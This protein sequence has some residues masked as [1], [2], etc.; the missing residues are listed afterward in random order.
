MPAEQPST[1]STP[2]GTHCSHP[3]QRTLSLW[4]ELY[5]CVSNFITDQKTLTMRLVLFGVRGDLKSTR[6]RFVGTVFRTT[7]LQQGKTEGAQ[8]ERPV[9]FSAHTYTAQKHSAAICYNCI[10]IIL[11]FAV[12][13]KCLGFFF[14]KHCKKKRIFLFRNSATYYS[15]EKLF[16]RYP[17]FSFEK[18]IKAPWQSSSICNK[19]L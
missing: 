5:L 17:S 12:Q 9:D 11:L 6:R 1:L 7:T 2:T 18:S 19:W 14:W 8:A 4:A 15:K 13:E 3:I 10:F 16:S